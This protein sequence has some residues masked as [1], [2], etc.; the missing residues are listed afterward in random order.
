MM[1]R[2]SEMSDN[3]ERGTEGGRS[4]DN[5]ELQKLAMILVLYSAMLL[6]SMLKPVLKRSYP[7]SKLTFKSARGTVLY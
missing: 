2:S 6:K 3:V 4:R 5:V 1:L 7:M